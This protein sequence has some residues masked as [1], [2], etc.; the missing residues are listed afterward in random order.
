MEL[1]KFT[2]FFNKR[3]KSKIYILFSSM[4]IASLLET[5]GLGLIFP[6]TG[7]ILE[8]VNETNN[9]YSNLFKN[10]FNFPKENLI[11]YSLILLVIIYFIKIIF[12]IWFTYFQTKFIYFFKENLSSGLFNNYLK[13]NF[14]FFYN[15]NS[16]EIL[17]NITTEV[18]NFSNYLISFL[19]LSLELFV[20]SFIIIL[21]IYLNPLVAFSVIGLFG[22]ISLIY[23]Y[24]FRK[25]IQLW[26]LERQTNSKEII[27][28]AQE[29][30][31]SLNY[32]KFVGKENFF[33]NKFKIKN[34][35]LAL[36]NVKFNFVK[37]LPKFVFEFIGIVSIIL[38]FYFYFKSGKNISETIQIL[39]VYFAASFRILPSINRILSNAQSMKFSGSA[40]FNLSNEFKEFKKQNINSFGEAKVQFNHDINLSIRRF[41]YLGKR[42]FNLENVGIKIKK[43]QKIGIMG[44]TGSGKST[45]IQ[46]ILGVI[47]N[48]EVE[49]IVDG[50]LVN[51]Q[52]RSWQNLICY[53]P[54]K[55][56]I[57]DDTLKNNILFGK[58]D[59]TK[60]N[61]KINEFI[62]ITQLDKLVNQ[63]PDGLDSKIGERG[64]NLSGGE[65]QRIAI[66][67]AL[68]EDKDIIV[69]DEVTSSLDKATSNYIIKH[70]FELKNKTII[71]VSHKNESLKN[72][73]LIYS[74]DKGKI[75]KIFSS[76][77]L[78]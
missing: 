44:K 15:K 74:F 1:E 53:V 66:C 19:R 28:F 10:L 67:R 70:I 26:S 4:L 24:S 52:S 33:F 2:N 75:E 69:L 16:A 23:F 7:I 25:K 31:G 47:K 63:L 42:D 54:Q 39:A 49:L 56:F 32:I 40:I 38:I 13:Q 35:G 8:N 9:V 59:T 30:F 37:E 18:N 65:I 73:D 27:Q 50:T 68:L 5:I 46:M 57:L 14:E 36:L 72:C 11:T 41:N 12:M 29:G 43:N 20:A 48:E 3:E 61:S 6:I 22:S 71:F 78:Q 45:I 17:R 51:S 58:E 21:L 76:N 34:F 60:N 55:I 64:Y 62:K 77:N